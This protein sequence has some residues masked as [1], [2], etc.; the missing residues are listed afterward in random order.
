MVYSWIKLHQAFQ[1]EVIYSSTQLQL[2]EQHKPT[3]IR[4]VS[5]YCH[6]VN[7]SVYAFAQF[8]HAMAH[9]HRVIA[10]LYFSLLHVQ[11]T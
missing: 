4:Y 1:E 3:A 10:C 8:E 11:N 6:S 9:F 5:V 7:V 2:S